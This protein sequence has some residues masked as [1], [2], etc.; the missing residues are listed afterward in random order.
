MLISVFAALALF[1][2]PEAA[3][4]G[5]SAPEATS[6]AEATPAAEAKPAVR[7]VCT[8]IQVSGTNLPKKK[9]KTVPVKPE[10]T[11]VAEE[12]SGKSAGAASE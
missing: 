2:A 10:P 1:A 6:A 7:K 9:C 4:S 12:A 5:G 11:K 8:T 3:Q